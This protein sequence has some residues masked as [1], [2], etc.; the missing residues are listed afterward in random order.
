MAGTLLV[1][2]QDVPQGRGEQ[3]VVGGQDGAAGKAEDNL[4]ALLLEAADEGLG[5]GELHRF[6]LHWGGLV[7]LSEGLG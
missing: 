2:D 4:R 5:S 3:R 1:P 7:G 6:L